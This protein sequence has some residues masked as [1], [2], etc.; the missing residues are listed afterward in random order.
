MSEDDKA[1][2]EQI[3]ALRALMAAL[4]EAKRQGWFFVLGDYCED[5]GS[6][7]DFDTAV[8]ACVEVVDPIVS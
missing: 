1:T 6:P 8:R 2:P 4:D 5:T 3:K 7:R